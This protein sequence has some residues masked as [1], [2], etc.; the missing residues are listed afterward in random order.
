MH[1]DK[2]SVL[3]SADPQG[4]SCY[5]QWYTVH[6]N[7]SQQ[8]EATAQWGLSTM[9]RLGILHSQKVYCS[10]EKSK[11]TVFCTGQSFIWAWKSAHKSNMKSNSD[12][13][14]WDSRTLPPPSPTM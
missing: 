9:G 8:R 3:T 1:P 12:P 10:A 11:S 14:V 4:I 6:K 5:P 7:V 2:V 13:N